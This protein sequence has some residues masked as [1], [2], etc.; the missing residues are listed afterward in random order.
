MSSIAADTDVKKMMACIQV[1]EDTCDE[2]TEDDVSMKE[3]ALEDL[4]MLV[5]NIDNANGR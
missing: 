3:E 1:L 2:N 4:S 5:D